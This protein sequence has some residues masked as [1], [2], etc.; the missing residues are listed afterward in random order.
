MTVQ[1]RL[2]E[3]FERGFSVLS[4][5]DR[6]SVVSA[7]GYLGRSLADCSQIRRQIKS[8]D[9][10]GAFSALSPSYQ[11]QA[12]AYVEN[13]PFGLAAVIAACKRGGLGKPTNATT[14][15]GGGIEGPGAGQLP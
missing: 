2:W 4:D 8:E 14:D 7:F 9:I 15:G 11:F 12:V 13:I 3:R 6:A 10:K 5:A 1:E